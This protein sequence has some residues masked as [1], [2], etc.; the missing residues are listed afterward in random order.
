MN[1][2][3]QVGLHTWISQ[4]IQVTNKQLGL[5]WNMQIL[6][7]P[8][9]WCL[10]YLSSWVFFFN[11]LH[12]GTILN[13]ILHSNIS[14]DQE[15]KRE[16]KPP[17]EC[18]IDIYQ[19]IIQITHCVHFRGAVLVG[20]IFPAVTCEHDQPHHTAESQSHLQGGKHH[21]AGPAGTGVGNRHFAFYFIFF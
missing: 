20:V 6:V 18:K 10:L 5:I 4:Y 21:V 3:L 2:S 14:R 15:E 16:E 9:F 8:S 17:N 11:T 19:K 13:F 1:T 12:P 7:V